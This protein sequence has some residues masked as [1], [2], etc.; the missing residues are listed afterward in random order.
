M[1]GPQRPKV[2]NLTH[3][4]VFR[5]AFPIVLSNATIPLPGTVDTAVIGQLEGD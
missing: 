1:N 3:F 4:R 5:I 2:T